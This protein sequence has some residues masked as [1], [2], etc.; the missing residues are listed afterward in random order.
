M[1]KVNKSRVSVDE[2]KRNEAAKRAQDEKN[3]TD[4]EEYI[5]L[6]KHKTKKT[7]AEIL[8]DMGSTNVDYIS[9]Q[10]SK[11]RFTPSFIAQFKEKYAEI[12]N[13]EVKKEVG[14]EDIEL[15]IHAIYHRQKVHG[16][17]LAELYAHQKGVSVARAL[18][19][20]EQ[21]EQENTTNV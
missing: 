21:Y 15:V 4:M 5:S 20:M 10:R 18:A 14:S 12:I 7:E 1:K 13:N 9:Q 2:T 3:M 8:M 11:G 6:V 19:E 17:Y 16:Y